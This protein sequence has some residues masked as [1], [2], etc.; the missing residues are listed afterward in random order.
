MYGFDLSFVNADLF[1]PHC[2][3]PPVSCSLPCTC[4]AYSSLDQLLACPYFICA[5][6]VL[7]HIPFLRHPSDWHAPYKQEVESCQG[8]MPEHTHSI[9]VMHSFAVDWQYRFSFYACVILLPY[10]WV[11]PSFWSFVISVTLLGYYGTKMW[12]MA[13]LLRTLQ[14]SYLCDTVL[15]AVADVLASIRGVRLGGT[16]MGTV[17][18]SFCSI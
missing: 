2:P 10:V 1:L 11:T 6:G 18:I 7:Q 9:F 8:P 12:W 15:T 16:S 4:A 3:P 13:G 5:S 17:C 14:P